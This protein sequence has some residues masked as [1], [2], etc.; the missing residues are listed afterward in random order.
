MQIKID[1]KW[2]SIR[3]TRSHSP[4]QYDSEDEAKNMLNLCYPNLLY[5]IEKKVL[6]VND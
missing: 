3:P 6:K 2:K 5:N 1:D 4:Y